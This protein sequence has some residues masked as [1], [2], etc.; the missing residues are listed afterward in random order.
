MVNEQLDKSKAINEANKVLRVEELTELNSQVVKILEKM[1]Q[2]LIDNKGKYSVLINSIPDNIRP[3]VFNVIS[4]EFS[5]M[6]NKQ[7]KLFNS[8]QLN[9]GDNKI[10]AD[11]SIYARA[12]K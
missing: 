2:I 9:F 7:E 5:Q 6:I 11:N 3:D 1:N 12:R 8:F 4:S 10:L